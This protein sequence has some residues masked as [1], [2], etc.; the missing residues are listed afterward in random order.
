MVF[1]NYTPLGAGVL[2]SSTIDYKCVGNTAFADISIST[3]RTITSGTGT[4]TF[5]VYQDPGRTTVMPG[6]PAIPLDVNGTTVTVWGFLPPQNSSPGAYTG[7]L[8]VTITSEGTT[9]RSRNLNVLTTNYVANCVV[10]PASLL[11][12]SYDPGSAAP[13]DAL[14]T[15]SVACTAGTPYTVSLGLGNNAAGAIR[16]MANGAA[17]LQ[18]ELYADAA[19]TAVWNGVNTVSG[20]AP[21]TSAIGLPV[22]GRIPPTQ[23]V[24]A[25]GYTDTV[26]ATINF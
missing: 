18:Y 19:R 26:Q 17:R 23:L 10:Q 20:T 7:T 1:S 14:G 2:A 15:I 8:T 9:T 3:P 6:T 13:R 24:A 4:M 16:Q 5:E 12:G 25:G 22:Y 21:T 11:F